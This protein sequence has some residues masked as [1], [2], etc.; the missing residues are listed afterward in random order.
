MLAEGQNH[1]ATRVSRWLALLAV[2]LSLLLA[3]TAIPARAELPQPYTTRDATR[4]VSWL[5]NDSVGLTASDVSFNAG[6]ASL[7][8]KP[9]SMAWNTA[10]AFITNQSTSSNVTGGSTGLTLTANLSNRLNNGNFSSAASWVYANGTADN[11]TAQWIQ[12]DGVAELN[13]TSRQTAIT[14]DPLSNIATNWTL[15]ASV[16]STSNVYQAGEDMGDFVNVSAGAAQFAGAQHVGAVNWAPYD[17]LRID[18]YQNASAPAGFNISAIDSTFHSQTTTA[19]ALSVGWQTVTVDLTQL[20][21]AR[22]SLSSLTLRIVGMGG[23]K[24]PPLNYNFAAI[25]LGVAKRADT[26][27]LV[28]QIFGKANATTSLPGSAYLSFDWMVDNFTGVALG[29]LGANL[30][31]PAG[32]HTTVLP[33]TTCS[34]CW[35]HFSADIS[36]YAALS[37]S[38]NL[39]FFLE[40]VLDNITVSNVTVFID[41]AAFVYPNRENGSY[42]S[43][44]I[45]LGTESKVVGITWSASLPSA[46][47]TSIHL[48]IRTGNTTS[49]MGSWYEF[50]GPGNYSQTEFGLY[51]QIRADLNTTNA[52][53]SPVLTG[54][55]LATTHRTSIGAIISGNYTAQSDFLFWRSFMVEASM[56]PSTVI[57]FSVG[58]G[59]SLTQVSPGENLSAD[60]IGARIQWKALFSS[61]D[62]LKSPTLANVSLVYDYLGPPARVAFTAFNQVLPAG[63]V[64]NVSAG[65]AVPLGVVVYDIGSHFIPAALYDIGWRIDNASGGSVW[66]NGTF[67]VGRPGRYVITATVAPSGGGS[68]FLASLQINVTASSG[69]STV[70][71]SLWDYWPI[72]LIVIAALAGVSIYELAIRRLFAIDDVFLIARDGRLII[73]NTRRMRADRDEDILSGM[74]TAIMAFLRDQDPE[75]NGE[76]KRFQVGGKTTLLERGEHVYLSAIFSGRVPGWAGKDLHRFMI[77]L[78]DRFG[79]AFASWNGSPENLRDLKEYMQRFVS[80]VRYRGDPSAAY[81]ET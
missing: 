35:R 2:G 66:P 53:L 81:K 54:L 80:H 6:N 57:S 63:T 3:W 58:D 62:G 8:W 43:K 76:L 78:E 40:V 18:I 51:F 34:L 32:T 13:H 79:R 10:T 12:S 61:S 72:F 14:W 74:L 59:N 45:S 22:S 26:T 24:L 46:P 75:E 31:G 20:G 36:P 1:T 41:N 60:G 44:P 68:P 64:L 23:R 17:Q 9:A 30:T 69:S 25:E 16:G 52:S 21:S 19:I 55:S 29:R 15:S 67:T 38:Y 50:S 48:G 47:A 37:G 4:T 33:L 71:P 5:M 49:A 73:H 39:S 56:P 65:Q 77:D 70:Q 11:T 7:A 28:S 27:A 42:I